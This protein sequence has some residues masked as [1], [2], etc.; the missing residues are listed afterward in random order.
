MYASIPARPSQNPS[1][2]LPSN[3]QPL[4]RSIPQMPYPRAYNA[5]APIPNPS[6]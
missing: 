2:P 1:K 4:E 5:H 3:A 6:S